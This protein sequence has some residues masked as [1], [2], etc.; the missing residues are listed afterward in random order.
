MTIHAYTDVGSSCPAYV[1]L[2]ERVACP[3]D[4]VL[5]VRSAGEN[6]ASSIILSRDQA[7]ALSSDVLRHYGAPTPDIKAAVDRFLGWK[8]PDTLYPDC[9]ISFDRERAKSSG[10][11]PIG[12]NLLNAEEARALFEHA[13]HEAKP[14]HPIEQL[15]KDCGGTLSGLTALPDGTG[16][17][18]LSLPLPADHWLTKPG[19][20]EPPMGFRKG[21]DD[22][23]RAEWAEKIRAA[24]RY[25]MRGATMNGTEDDIDPDAL[26]QNL[27]V[28]MLGY[29]TPDGLSHVGELEAPATD[30]SGLPG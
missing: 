21:T 16:S 26:V 27:I 9:F 11:W 15:A 14:L 25:A 8:L 22:P 24:G 6:S 10:S 28:G 20:D 12:T 7:L 1:N 29:F 2:S 18:T 3:G 4:V 23:E 19:Y 17:A 5:T 30:T 13:L